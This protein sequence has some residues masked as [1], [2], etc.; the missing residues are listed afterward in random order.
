MFCSIFEEMNNAL[1]YLLTV[2]SRK[3]VND[4]K[5]LYYNSFHAVSGIWTWLLVGPWLVSPDCE[6]KYLGFLSAMCF[7]THL[8]RH[9]TESVLGN[10]QT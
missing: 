5:Y 7:S 3:F 9:S 4:V 2:L 10:L 8:S 6:L 1:S